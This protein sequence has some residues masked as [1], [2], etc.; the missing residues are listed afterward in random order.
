MLKSNPIGGQRDFVGR[1]SDEEFLEAIFGLPFHQRSVSFLE[2]LNLQDTLD[3][4]S[5]DFHNFLNLKGLR[6]IMNIF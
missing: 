3:E 5:R 2:I 4:I 1:I 6:L